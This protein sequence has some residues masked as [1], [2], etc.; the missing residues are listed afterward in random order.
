MAYIII[1]VLTHI[2][3]NNRKWN[4][5]KTTKQ[6]SKTLKFAEKWPKAKT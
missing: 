6:K 5:T 2:K 3:F 1:D 4:R